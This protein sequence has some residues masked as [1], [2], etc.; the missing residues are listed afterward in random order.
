MRVLLGVLLFFLGGVLLGFVG[1]AAWAVTWGLLILYLAVIW[2]GHAG[3]VDRL[4]GRIGAS[5]PAMRI[6]LALAAVVFVIGA[7]ELAAHVFTR[8]FGTELPSPMR[9]LVT[10]DTEDWRRAHMTAD[11]LR[12]PDP[13]L[14]WRPVASKPYN[15]Q[16]FKGP[17]AEVPKPPGV[18][19]IMTYGDSN[20]DG[21]PRG[22][23]PGQLQKVLNETAPEETRFEVLNAGVAGYSSYQ[24]LTR[25]REEIV[26][27]D[28]DLIL[29]SFG[30][31]DLADALG[32]P[33]QSFEA[34]SRLW[35]A[36]ERRL[37]RF[38]FYR[39]LRQ[40][41]APTQGERTGARVPLD[42]Y[43]ENMRQFQQV[44]AENDAEILILT[45]PTRN[46]AE[47][48]R[49]LA[50]N[51][52]AGVPDYNDALLKLGTEEQ[53]PV[54]DVQEWFQQNHPREFVDESHFTKEGHRQMA[55]LLE[56][57]IAPTAARR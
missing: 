21:P 4:A 14:L 27:Y 1:P 11:S 51:W 6:L 48:L 56:G 28:P 46:P 54:V 30:W 7:S 29:V 39:L 20:T 3:P 52:R 9:T 37:L 25:L 55:R 15:T 26:V 33:D 17:L 5:G 50:P 38:R 43:L 10:S 53:L 45:R 34:P 18:F 22:A 36:T 47:K 31:N 13:A 12:E 24:G 41:A 57:R 49:R 16:R 35:L 19:R 44:A 32:A 2:T 23:W 42:D 40:W 8:F